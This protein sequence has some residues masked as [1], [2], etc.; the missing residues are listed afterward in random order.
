M[1][2][3][4]PATCPNLLNLKKKSCEDL[5]ALLVEALEKQ[6]AEG[7]DVEGMDADKEREA[8]RALQEEGGGAE[9]GDIE[10]DGEGHSESEDGGSAG[11][12]A[13]LATSAAGG[14][15][16]GGEAESKKPA[17]RSKKARGRGASSGEEGEDDG[18]PTGTTKRRKR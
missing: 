10:D 17:S 8:W 7:G 9:E 3:R 2:D 14:A 5:K 15:E 1:Q 16:T 11:G 18:K 13:E 12:E 4:D 6:R